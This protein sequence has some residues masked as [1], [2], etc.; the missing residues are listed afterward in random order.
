MNQRIAAGV[1]V[2]LL[3][4][5]GWGNYAYVSG[6]SD[7][8]HQLRTGICTQEAQGQ[9]ASAGFDR[10]LRLLAQRAE[11]RERVDIRAGNT[12]AAQADAD[13]FRLYTR[14]AAAS[15]HPQHISYC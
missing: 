10:L 1:V 11:A 2:V 4:L 5:A 9:K 8:L 12:T 6:V 3:L 7:Q 13:S 15:A 14:V